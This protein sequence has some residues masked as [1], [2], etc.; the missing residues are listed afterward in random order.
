ML[1]SG[2][3]FPASF[4]LVKHDNPLAVG[5]DRADDILYFASSTDILKV[6]LPKI[7]HRGFLFLEQSRFFFSDLANDTGLVVNHNG[8]MRKFDIQPRQY[9]YR[10]SWEPMF[11]RAEMDE[12][13]E[14]VESLASIWKILACLSVKIAF[15]LTDTILKDMRLVIIL[16]SKRSFERRRAWK[17]C[18]NWVPCVSQEE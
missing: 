6:S 18:L 7:N 4:L 16:K 15:N 17:N 13:C 8:L 3:G 1:L 12:A 2:Q 5:F 9:S 10:Y 11:P 14:F